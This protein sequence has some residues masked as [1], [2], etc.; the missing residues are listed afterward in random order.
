MFSRIE[1]KDEGDE[2]HLLGL[3]TP[4]GMIHYAKLRWALP[5]EFRV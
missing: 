4:A 3:H 1:G 2:S 5:A